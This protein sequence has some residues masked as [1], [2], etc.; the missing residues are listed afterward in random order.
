MVW[1]TAHYFWH[2]AFLGQGFGEI[3]F[4][5]LREARLSPAL[6]TFFSLLKTL[7]LDLAFLLIFWVWGRRTGKFLGFKAS[8]SMGLLLETALGMAWAQLFWVGLGLNRLWDEKLIF[9]LGLLILGV[10]LWDLAQA[11]LKKSTD[12][13][14]PRL[15]DSKEDIT[16]WETIKN[17]TVF[18]WILGSFCLLVALF[19]LGQAALP[20]V[21]FDS[22]TYHL[23]ALNN[24]DQAHGIANL[25]TNLYTA[26]PFGGEMDFFGVFHWGSSEAVKGL[27]VLILILTALAAGAWAREEDGNNAGF[28]AAGLVLGF[29]LVVTGAWSAQVDVLQ[30]FFIVLFYYTLSKGKG[31]PSSFW[32]AGVLAGAILAV[33]YTALLSLG[34]G[35]LVWGTGLV[36]SIKKRPSLLW[37]WI[38]PPLVLFL[39]WLLKNWA[40]TANPLYPYFGSWFSGLGLP[41]ERMSQLMR[42]HVQAFSSGETLPL[43][44]QRVFTRD[45]DK[46]IAPIL[47]SF[48]PLLFLGRGIKNQN[49]KILTVGGL[50]L[51]LSLAVTHQLRLGLG[52]LIVCFVG[53]GLFVEG[54]RDQWFRKGFKAA[55]IVF[56]ILN[57]MSVIRLGVLYYGDT[58]VWGGEETRQEYLTLRPQT[59]TYFPLAQDCSKWFT[60]NDKLLVAGDARG[61]YYPVPVVT[62][63]VFDDQVMER[64]ARESSN[65][66]EIA[67]GLK[68]IGVT[69]LVVLRIEGMRLSSDYDPYP[70]DEAA[71]TR[72]DDF[73]Q[74]HTRLM[75]MTR[76]G[77]IYRFSPDSL[78]KQAPV[79]DLFQCFKT[80][81]GP[82]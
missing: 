15:Q 69:G 6:S 76:L 5:D 2:A 35:L 30:A 68:E 10:A 29:P 47:F 58:L 36:P 20:D 43:W 21:Y 26:F 7:L 16:L 40:Y 67:L 3:F 64:L 25:S 79:S 13:L 81:S 1:L 33:K 31:T 8:S 59:L 9:P 75:E 44:V 65:G 22:L 52:A 17:L 49:L 73:I 57:F 51:L 74:H 71:W 45:L 4:G 62:N 63:S 42:D 38:I 11:F 27:N 72:L 19:S 28:L 39:P 18:N 78:P 41:P 23:Y 70:M 50:S 48:L 14:P 80:P 55:L 77:G 56:F 32:M 61:L 60:P 34:V 54:L 66:D 46:T 82:L 24:W 53:M 37:G 12:D